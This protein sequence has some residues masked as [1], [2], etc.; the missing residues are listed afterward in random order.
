MVAAQE[1]W[2]LVAQTL[3]CLATMVLTPRTLT[4][5]VKSAIQMRM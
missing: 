2:R 5:A 3:M 1:A 4:T